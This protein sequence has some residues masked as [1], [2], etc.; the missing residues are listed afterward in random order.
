MP[1]RELR[2]AAACAA[3]DSVEEVADALGLSF[4]TTRGYIHAM[5]FKIPGTLPA[6]TKVKVWARG[7]T[8]TVLQGHE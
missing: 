2:I 5:S 3:L 4:H 7:A 6:F 1:R 8:L